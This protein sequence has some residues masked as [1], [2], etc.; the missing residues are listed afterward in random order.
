VAKAPSGFVPVVGGDDLAIEDRQLRQNR[1]GHQKR[2]RFAGDRR[3]FEIEIRQVQVPGQVKELSSIGNPIEAERKS[4]HLVTTIVTQMGVTFSMC[5]QQNFR[6]H[7][8]HCRS[9][10]VVKNLVPKKG[11]LGLPRKYHCFC[12]NEIQQFPQFRIPLNDSVD[13]SAKGQLK[14]LHWCFCLGHK[15]FKRCVAVFTA[16][17]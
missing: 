4:G 1:S 7:F 16:S 9:I 12:Q 5:N 11:I 14:Y 2:F 15:T 13:S 8:F 6:Y 3:A 17:Y 10:I